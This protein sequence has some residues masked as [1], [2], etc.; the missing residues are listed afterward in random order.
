MEVN[1]KPRGQD[2]PII[3]Q[4]HNI[5]KPDTTGVAARWYNLGIQ[6]NMETGTLDSIKADNPND[7]NASCTAM[8]NQWLRTTPDASWNKLVCALNSIDMS[9][10]ASDLDRQLT[11][12]NEDE[13]STKSSGS[14]SAPF[15]TPH[16]GSIEF[17]M[18][19][20]RIIKE[21]KQNEVENLEIIKSVCSQLTVRD[22][23]HVLLF[24]ED[25]QEDINACNN[26]HNMFN[27]NLRRCW[28]WDDF[29]LLKLLLQSLECSDH[30]EVM[31]AQYEEKLDSQ[32]K[33]QQIYEHCMQEHQEI[34]AGY[35]KM[36][37]V[38]KNKLFSR[39]TKEEYDELKRFISEHCGVKPYVIPPFHKAGRSSL[40]LEFIVPLTAVSHM[41]ETATKNINKFQDASFVYLKIASTLLFDITDTIHT[42]TES[43]FET[44]LCNVDI[45]QIVPKLL[46]L[47]LLSPEDCDELGS[48][49]EKELIQ[50]ADD[51]GATEIKFMIDPRRHSTD[52]LWLPGLAKFQGPALLSWNNAQFTE[53]D[54]ESISK[55][56]QNLKDTDPMKVGRFGLGFISIHHITGVSLLDVDPSPTSIVELSL[57]EFNDSILGLDLPFI[58]SNDTIAVLD[59]H[60]VYINKKDKDG[61]LKTGDWLYLK[62]FRRY[63]GSVSCFKG[64]FGYSP[65]QDQ[66]KGAIFRFPLRNCPSDISDS[67]LNSEVVVTKLFKSLVEDGPFL[68]LFLKNISSIGLYRYDIYTGQE[69]LLYQIRVDHSNVSAVQQGRNKCTQSAENWERRTDMFCHINSVPITFENHFMETVPKEGRYN[70][71][72]MNCIAGMNCDKLQSLSKKLKVIPWVG[73]AAQLPSLL[74]IP[75]CSTSVSSK[76]LDVCDRSVTNFLTLLSRF[77]KKI[78]W[79]FDKPPDIPGHAFCF[80]PLPSKIGLPVCIHGYFSVADNRRSI[81]W[82]S[83]DEQGEEAQFN[84]ALVDDLIT[85][86]YAILLACRSALIEYAN[87]PVLYK[88]SHEMLDPYCLWPLLSQSS[89]GHSMWLTLVEQVITLLVNN[90][91]KVAWTA[92]SGGQRISLLSALYLPG[93]FSDVESDVSEVIVE[94]LIALNQPLVILP[95]AVTQVIRN[96]QP[97]RAKLQSREISPSVVRNCL[98]NAAISQVQ[99]IVVDKVKCSSLLAY[100]LSD[101]SSTNCHELLNI[102]LL[103]V[104]KAGALPKP[105]SQQDCICM[106][107]DKKCVSFLQEI[108][109]QLLWNELPLD[110]LKQLKVVIGL[111]LYQL[112]MADAK[113][114]CSELI[115]MSM[116]KWTNSN[117][118]EVQWIPNANRH[119]PLQWLLNLWEWLNVALFKHIGIDN[120]LTLSIFPKECLDMSP[121]PSIINLFPLSHCSTCFLYEQEVPNFLPSFVERIGFTV[122]HETRFVFMQSQIKS[123]FNPIS[124]KSIIKVLGSSTD[125]RN[126]TRCVENQ[127]PGDKVGFL[128]YISLTNKTSLSIT[129]VNAIRQL[130]LFNPAN[131]RQKFVAL[132]TTEWILLTEGMQLPP[133]LQYPPNIIHYRSLSE[134]GL[135]KLLGC[136]QPTFTELC[137]T[138]I[139]P[140]ALNGNV[141][142]TN[143]LMKWILGSQIDQTLSNHLHSC[144][145]VPRGTSKQLAKPSELYDP[146]D[147]KFQ[148][149]FDPQEDCMPS[150]EYRDYFA[151]LRRLGLKTWNIVSSDM[152][153]LSQLLIERA[154]TVSALCRTNV[155]QIFNRSFMI[156]YLLREISN[157]DSEL[158]EILTDIPFLFA[159]PRPPD[160]D[161]PRQLRWYGEEKTAYSP[162]NMYPVHC[163]LLVGSI[164]PVLH[165][166]Y[167]QVEC[168]SLAGMMKSLYMS[169][170]FSQLTAL[171][172][173]SIPSR[174]ISKIVYLIYD[175]LHLEE[176]KMLTGNQSN[177]PSKWIWIEAECKFVSAEKCAVY[178]ID[179]LD[180]SPYYYTLSLIPQLKEYHGMFLSLGV[181]ANFAE[182][183]VSKAFSE[184]KSFFRGYTLDDRH[185]RIVL[186]ILQWIHQAGKENMEVLLPTENR[187]LLPPKDCT[188]ND[189]YWSGEQ[190]KKKNYTFVHPEIPLERAKFFKVVP[191]GQRLAPSRKLGLKYIQKGP[192]Q[193]VTSRL[194]EAIEDYGSDVDV[195]KELI[196][197][198]DDARATEVKFLIDWRQHPC[199]SLLE[200]EMK[201]WQGPA[202]LAYNNAVFT[203]SDLENICDLAGGSKKSDPTKIGRFGIGFCSIYHLTDVPSFITH[204]YFTVFD[205]HTSYLG[206]RVSSGEPGMQIDLKENFGDLDEFRDQFMPYIGMFDFDLTKVNKGYNGTLFRFPFRNYNTAAKSKISPMVYDKLR[207]ERLCNTLKESAPELLLFLQHVKEV[208]LYELEANSS[209]ENMKC[210]LS[211]TKTLDPNSAVTV[212]PTLIEQFRLGLVSSKSHQKKVFKVEGVATQGKYEHHWMV[213]SCLG[214]D[215]SKRL[216]QSGDGKS[217]G[218]CPLAEIGVKLNKSSSFIH[219][220]ISDG[221]LF[222]FLPLPIQCNLKFYCSGYFDISK[223]RRW[224]KKDSSGRLTEWNSAVISDAL[225]NCFVNTIV[226]LTELCSLS[227]VSEPDKKEFL[228][229]Y[230]SLWSTSESSHNEI[231]KTLFH[232]IKKNIHLTDKLI[233]WSDVNGGKWLSPKNAY[234]YSHVFNHNPQPEIRNEI[235]SLLLK[236]KYPVVDIPYNIKSILEESVP[237]ITYEDFCVKVLIPHIATLPAETRD[238]QIITLLLYLDSSFH[239]HWA[240]K[241]L[242]QIP[243]IPTKPFGSLKRPVDLI[244]PKSHLAPLY[245]DS[246][247]CFPMDTYM[248]DDRVVSVLKRLGMSDY[249]FT[250][251]KLKDKALS[252]KKISDEEAAIQRSKQVLMYIS[253]VHGYGSFHDRRNHELYSTLQSVPFVPVS[254]CPQGLSLPWYKPPSLFQC[255]KDVFGYS[256]MNLVFTQAPVVMSFDSVSNSTIANSLNILRIDSKQPT[257]KF[258]VTHLVQLVEHVKQNPV[259]DIDT[260]MLNNCCPAVYKCLCEAGQ[261]EFSTSVFKSLKGLPFIW[262]NDEFL[263]I[264]Q[265][266]LYSGI[267]CGHPYLYDLSDENK[268]YKELFLKLGLLNELDKTKILRLLGEVYQSYTPNKKLTGE[269]VQFVFNLAQNLKQFLHHPNECYSV[270]YLPNEDGFMRPANKLAYRETVDLP[271]L[272]KSEILSKHFEAGTSW[273]HPTFSG[274]LAKSLGIPSALNSILNKIS[275]SNFLDG[276]DYGQSEDLCDRLNSILRKYPHDESIFKEFIQNA[277]DAGASEIVFILDHRKFNPQDDKLFSREPEWKSIHQC[278]SLLVYN[279]RKMSEEDIDRITK[280][281]QEGEEFTLEGFGI[282]LNIAYHVTDCL[283]FV[284]YGSRGVPEN[285]CIVDPGGLY[286]PGHHK[287]SMHSRQFEVNSHAILQLF[288]KEF[289]PFY[290]DVFVQMSKLCENCLSDIQ[291]DFSNGCVVF[292]LPFTRS[293]FTYRSELKDGFK[294]NSMEMKKLF[295]T[296]ANSAEDLVL[297]LSNIKSISAFEIME[298]STCVH[299]F[300]TSASLSNNGVSTC[301]E[302]AALVKQEIR[303]LKEITKTVNDSSQSNEVSTDNE[304]GGGTLKDNASL[305]EIS[306]NYQ[307]EIETIKH[308]IDPMSDK[309]TPYHTTSLWLIS[310]HFGK[311]IHASA[312]QWKFFGG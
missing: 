250:M 106:L 148:Y 68:L 304:G 111:N 273:L 228:A 153:C 183:V 129:E 163:K 62:D 255:P 139:I 122:V 13:R 99:S 87:F 277:D 301:K 311:V 98:R 223:D 9:Q 104:E 31:L 38:V 103:P 158:L 75:E 114:V 116:R 208:S 48:K 22:N 195:F 224:L 154:S 171:S 221:K 243:S 160:R 141:N 298:N 280:L 207:V 169:D 296:L 14:T 126:I 168:Q 108:T 293:L 299:H 238:K 43:E 232:E 282:G 193:S 297:F 240:K 262:Q 117:G 202:L 159:S 184:T 227:A 10:A 125:I 123:K 80:L 192:H 140:F 131:N 7:V 309:H 91:L 50:N 162:R 289:E 115:P 60:R 144:K 272:T 203:S 105:F 61:S 310:Q 112:K 308:R 278:P 254:K 95:I 205:P 118:D 256:Q 198:A 138:H 81:K 265:V 11:G 294:M 147:P 134:C 248:I 190:M 288:S 130:P 239:A 165:E 257:I 58:L 37:A 188:Y 64:L 300:S 201:P 244:N 86:L 167:M 36:V 259:N 295:K 18:L 34:P 25:Q 53:N 132:N 149:L 286:I 29:Y 41:I 35:E 222:C 187:R 67:L 16:Q 89:G 59:P 151:I 279:N 305:N 73:V 72:V 66:Y 249:E 230:Y 177:L 236:H 145:F 70:W 128:K 6:L 164:A 237:K 79:E 77:K 292:R 150:S 52:E 290:G 283:T 88:N 178:P 57:E 231:S 136:P 47:A 74:Q 20:A 27:K 82:P 28:R 137:I 44:V 5:L 152:K 179:N 155:T 32:M 213:T 245:C 291:A 56:H 30:C 176:Q 84:K 65:E 312:H 39:I 71:L 127:L 8:F 191:L 170:L 200:P 284:S 157:P 235:V 302:N 46:N 97:L 161:Y 45:N 51:A 214:T 182:S 93:T 181:P 119:P 90:D 220:Q 17:G 92:A 226:A 12:I 21:L 166:H 94:T 264:S 100:V 306:W 271:N 215:K 274:E 26:L 285:Y 33:L 211:V 281:G 199:N 287:R 3:K 276:T 196:Q 109:D 55:I 268:K 135:L 258:V 260:E 2:S 206:G 242:T 210:V 303:I 24:N 78:P 185:L 42:M 189:R 217:N 19:M 180:L 101:V 219:P 76:N 234:L 253:H 247:E 233:L 85:P 197:N 23:P 174:E 175:H 1:S 63:T 204:N 209:V 269:H 49:P 186:H 229:A 133:L 146:D 107:A 225:Y 173:V 263:A 121:T 15:T 4:I 102:S 54:W 143:G 83:H 156:V 218:L 124:P 270:L 96:I 40:R 241:L 216:A 113:V 172:K 267:V 275:V 110:V 266:V 120:I 307:L 251:D 252:V 142:N 246:D 261:H 194:N 69:K 212:G